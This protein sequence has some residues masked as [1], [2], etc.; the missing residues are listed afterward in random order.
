MEKNEKKMEKVIGTNCYNCKF[1]TDK[2]VAVDPKELN[3]EGGINPRNKKKW[4][5]PKKLT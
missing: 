4:K 3:D 1:I 2:E 5:E